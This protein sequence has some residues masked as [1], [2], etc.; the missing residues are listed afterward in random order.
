M[1]TSWSS[2]SIAITTAG[3]SRQNSI[4]NFSSSNDL[5]LCAHFRPAHEIYIGNYPGRFREADVRNLFTENNVTVKDIRLKHDG[6][7]V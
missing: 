6:Q 4:K 5:L 7:K 1:K 2:G 3:S